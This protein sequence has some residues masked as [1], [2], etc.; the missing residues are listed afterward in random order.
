MPETWLILFSDLNRDTATKLGTCFLQSPKFI[1]KKLSEEKLYRAV[2]AI[3]GKGVK[4]NYLNA[5]ISLLLLTNKLIT[6]NS[7]AICCLAFYNTH[8]EGI[9]ICESLWICVTRKTYSIICW[10]GKLGPSYIYICIRQDFWQH[11]H[12]RPWHDVW[13]IARAHAV[14]RANQEKGGLGGRWK[15]CSKVKLCGLIL[16]APN[17]K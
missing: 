13:A 4:W 16:P 15:A 11:A 12:T 3:K 2:R 8:H 9:L 5:M 6:T 14:T 17:S 1:I 7:W 10:T